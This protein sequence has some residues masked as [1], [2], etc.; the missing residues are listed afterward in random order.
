VFEEGASKGTTY[1]EEGQKGGPEDGHQMK[2]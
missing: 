2:L 1:R